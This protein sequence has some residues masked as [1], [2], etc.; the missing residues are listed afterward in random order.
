MTA[1]L[2]LDG[3]RLEFGEAMIVTSASRCAKQNARVGGK[4]G[5]FHKKGCAFDIACP[6]GF[7]MRR[8]VLLALK[9]GFTVG[10]AAGFI[11]LDTRP[12]PP[13]LFGY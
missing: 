8:L 2:K 5:S 10:V 12:G 4:P 1:A 6:D 13:L 7:Y 9:H 3:L 11:H